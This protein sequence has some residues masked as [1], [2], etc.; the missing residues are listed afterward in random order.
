MVALA[1]A[2]PRVR[3]RLRLDDRV[4]H[5]LDAVERRGVLV[6]S[7]DRGSEVDYVF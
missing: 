2:V 1:A 7:D 3:A 4:H 6:P 5:E